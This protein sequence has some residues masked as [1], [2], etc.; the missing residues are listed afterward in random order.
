MM[1]HAIVGAR[2]LVAMVV[3]AGVAVWGLHLYPVQTANP[4]LGLIQLERP[5]VFQVLAYGYATLWSTTPF[6]AASLFT[7]LLAIIVYRYPQTTRAR[8]LPPYTP[9]ES[10]PAPTLVLGETHFLGASGERRRPRG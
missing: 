10:R 9:P 6:L 7:S 3:A 2:V 8:A 4:F 1:L 5:L